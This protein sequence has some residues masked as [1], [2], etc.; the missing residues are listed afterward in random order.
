MP[1]TSSPTATIGDEKSP[2][3]TTPAV[4]P[5]EFFS[6]A[7]LAARLGVSVRTLQQWHRVRKGPPLVAVGNFRAYRI[8]G[9]SQWLA[10][11]ETAVT[12]SS[13]R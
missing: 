12:R 11:H 3:P 13:K 9:F 4:I 2:K 10:D 6:P 8:L 5:A 7:D 1:R